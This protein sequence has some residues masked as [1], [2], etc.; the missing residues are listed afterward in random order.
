MMAP[1]TISGYAAVFNSV[2]K[3]GGQFFEVIAPGA[4][5]DTLKNEDVRALFNHREDHVLGRLSAR[6]LRLTEDA[7]GLRYDIVVNQ[8]D[9]MAISVAAKIKRG[10]VS[11]S[12]FSFVIDRPEDERWERAKGASLPLRTMLRLRLIDIGPVAFPA[13]AA[14]TAGTRTVTTDP[15]GMLRFAEAKLAMARRARV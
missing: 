10:D 3:I 4:F 12:S 14:T 15:A 6:T 1:T 8:D 5:A 11:G 9:P 2:T 13:Y 7:H